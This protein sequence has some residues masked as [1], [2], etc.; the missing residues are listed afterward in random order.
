MVL[1]SPGLSRPVCGV[2]GHYSCWGLRKTVLPAGASVGCAI[3]QAGGERGV[4]LVP[5]VGGCQVK[6]GW[7][8]RLD[9]DLKALE[10]LYK[11]S[12]ELGS[13]TL[14]EARYVLTTPSLVAAASEEQ[15]YQEASTVVKTLRGAYHVVYGSLRDLRV[16]ALIWKGPSGTTQVA[17]YLPSGGSVGPAETTETKDKQLD[18]LRTVVNAGLKFNEVGQVLATL[19]TD[20]YAAYR[21]ALEVIIHDVCTRHQP[22]TCKDAI[23]KVL[24]VTW[25]D[26]EKLTLNLN[27]PMLSGERAV[28]ALSKGSAPRR[29]LGVTPEEVSR[30]VHTWVL[31][32]ILAKH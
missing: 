30:T 22:L 25:N 28:H 6:V 1:V 18:L 16:A 20:D 8:A 27:N 23:R 4:R 11:A 5:E 2:G 24:A 3:L 26:Y 29:S 12:P 17:E 21:K 14:Y 31:R 19:E 13:I 15:A 7:H 9:G 10:D 32:W